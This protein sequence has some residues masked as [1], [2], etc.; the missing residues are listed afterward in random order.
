M[1][2]PRHREGKKRR[3]NK[4][5]NSN[6]VNLLKWRKCNTAEPRAICKELLLVTERNPF[7]MPQEVSGLSSCLNSS[8]SVTEKTRN[9]EKEEKEERERE[10]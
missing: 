6:G 10:W 7:W 2:I 3:K 9:K 1:K 8:R 5:K 4:R